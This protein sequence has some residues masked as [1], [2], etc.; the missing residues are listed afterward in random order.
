MVLV[1]L[2]KKNEAQLNTENNVTT[3]ADFQL[4]KDIEALSYQSKLN[5]IYQ[6]T[7]DIQR[8]NLSRITKITE[9]LMIK[10]SGLT[11]FYNSESFIKISKST[12]ITISE[13]LA[14]Y[15]KDIRLMIKPIISTPSTDLKVNEL[16]TLLE[17]IPVR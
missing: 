14:N 7:E 15:F 12:L 16:A 6:Y 17:G 11:S 8:E 5:K 3:K 4:I 9:E 13:T 2:E 10:L 1:N